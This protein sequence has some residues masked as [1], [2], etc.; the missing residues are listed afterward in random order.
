M[1]KALTLLA[2]VTTASA[3]PSYYLRDSSCYEAENAT[4]CDADLKVCEDLFT[5]DKDEQARRDIY[6][7]CLDENDFSQL[8]DV[9]P[10]ILFSPTGLEAL[11]L[12]GS[13]EKHEALKQCVLRER[14]EVQPDGTVDPQP[15][16]D[17][18]TLAL[19]DTRPDILERLLYTAESCSIENFSQ[20]DDW[21]TCVLSGCVR[22]DLPTPEPTT[23]APEEE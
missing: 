13:E 23:D 1:I 8:H 5:G 19:N 17:R 14:G 9:D 6:K 12:F 15:F 7:K 18:L 10:E 16:V 3:L 2:A 21:K 4:L 11:S 22:Q 20:I